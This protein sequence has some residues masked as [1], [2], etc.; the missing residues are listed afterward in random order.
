MRPSSQAIP[1][2]TS[3]LLLRVIQG[4]GWEFEANNVLLSNPVSGLS[5][6]LCPAVA[7]HLQLGYSR[8]LRDLTWLQIGGSFSTNWMFSKFKSKMNV[9]GRLVTFSKFLCR[10]LLF[11]QCCVTDNSNPCGLSD[12]LSLYWLQEL[13]S[14]EDI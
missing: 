10:P 4:T 11:R 12:F 8:Q 7:M 13:T 6:L 14:T 5:A 1:P 9:S 3:Y 2:A